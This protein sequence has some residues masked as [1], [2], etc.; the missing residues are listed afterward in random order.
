LLATCGYFAELFA[1]SS[2]NEIQK[3]NPKAC[4]GQYVIRGSDG[5]LER[6]SVYRVVQSIR[7]LYSYSTRKVAEYF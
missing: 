2:C 7:L 5:T 6:A 1:C 4:S 3:R